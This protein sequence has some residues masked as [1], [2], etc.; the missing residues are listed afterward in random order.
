MRKYVTQNKTY[1]VQ[2]TG[3]KERI[4][5]SSGRNE[6]KYYEVVGFA[7]PTANI[8]T[9]YMSDQLVIYQDHREIDYDKLPDILEKRPAPG[10]RI[11]ARLVNEKGEIAPR[12]APDNIM[13]TS[14]ITK[15]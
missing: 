4:R 11:I 7:P 15:I 14:S 12:S 13:I 8:Y 9:I 6:G 1:D 2:R 10:A 3:D 5:A